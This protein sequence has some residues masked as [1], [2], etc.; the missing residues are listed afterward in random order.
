MMKQLIIGIGLVGLSFC[1]GCSTEAGL[2]ADTFGQ[3]VAV[4]IQ[5]F[6]LQV[7][8]AVAL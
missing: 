3:N 7:L 8:A 5:D 2:T 4:F 1:W 6:I